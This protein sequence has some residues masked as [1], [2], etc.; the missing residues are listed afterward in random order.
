ME[1]KNEDGSDNDLQMDF[2]LEDYDFSSPWQ[3][4]SLTRTV[5]GMEL[6]KMPESES[7]TEG[8]RTVH[9]PSVRNDLSEE[10]PDTPVEIPQNVPKPSPEKDLEEEINSAQIIYEE[11]AEVSDKEERLE[12]DTKESTDKVVEQAES[13]KTEENSPD[14]VGDDKDENVDE[15]K[16]TLPEGNADNSWAKRIALNLSVLI[17]AWILYR[18][19]ITHVQEGEL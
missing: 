17:L 18:A 2:E 16:N 1:N 19:Y 8:T 10:E 4:T 11:D 9:Q 14:K 5:G 12:R 3:V 7:I 13:L 6:G 15:K